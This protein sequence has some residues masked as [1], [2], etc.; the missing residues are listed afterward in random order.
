MDPKPPSSGGDAAARLRGLRRCAGVWLL[1]PMNEPGRLGG[2]IGGTEHKLSVGRPL[3]PEERRL[4]LAE[5]IRSAGSVTVAMIEE[6]V[7][8]S[9]MTARRAREVL[10]RS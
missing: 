8:I 10:E 9:P 5:R 7:G 6:E 1:L 2:D 4:R 3:L